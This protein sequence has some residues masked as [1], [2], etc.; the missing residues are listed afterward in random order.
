MKSCRAIGSLPSQN[1]SSLSV[2]R[3]IMAQF[4]T[5]ECSSSYDTKSGS[6]RQNKVR[7]LDPEVCG[8]SWA[9]D[10]VKSFTEINGGQNSSVWRPLL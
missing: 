6:S 4:P 10:R 3:G 1:T 5:S 9:P 7:D 2:F 8:K